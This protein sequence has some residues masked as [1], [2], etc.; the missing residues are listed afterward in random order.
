[1]DSLSPEPPGKT[2]VELGIIKS[3][4][5]H[6]ISKSFDAFYLK[7]YTMKLLAINVKNVEENSSSGKE[8]IS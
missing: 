7:T 3:L 4:I 5:S 6:L 1:M 8:A 2:V